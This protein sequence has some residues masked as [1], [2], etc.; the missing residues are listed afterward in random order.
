MIFA[1]S[2]AATPTLAAGGETGL[3]TRSQ[4]APRPPAR[5]EG[6]THLYL[7]DQG[8]TVSTTGAA[9][10]HPVGNRLWLRLKAVADV[11]A[12]DPGTPAD[13]AHHVHDP[14]GEAMDDMAFDAV[15][16][17]SARGGN[18]R[19]LRSE[20][21]A[22]LLFRD[23]WKGRPLELG[24]DGHASIEPDYQS[25]GGAAHGSLS[26][27]QGNITVSGYMGVSEDRIAPEDDP[28]GRDYLFPAFLGK[29][30]AGLA[31]SWI[32]TPRLALSGGASG[33]VQ[34][35]YLSSPYRG[36]VMNGMPY[37][38]RLPGQR[39][40]GTAFVQGSLYLGAGT[41]LHVRQG[42][43]A[44]DWGVRAYIPETA[45]AKE[46]GPRFMATIRHRYYIQTA[47]DFYGTAYDAYRTIRAGDVRLGR[48]DEQTAGAELEWKTPGAAQ[49]LGPLSIS[50][51]YEYAHLAYWDR[52][53]EELA[54]HVLVL[55]AALE[56]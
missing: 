12:V 7:D 5:L 15:S 54:G 44:D 27:A 32:A 3:L 36:A 18:S 31:L 39:V 13:T 24:L 10:E 55:G 6:Q 47:A 38:E 21:A 28:H 52:P 2:A 34:K 40:R 17:A 4:S 43:Y 50:I 35:G 51:G 14:S 25:F 30:S 8:L 42:A 45:L 20:G 48:L 41:A 19:E 23:A 29:Y 46:I 11:I 56:Y 1:I 33:A 9:L 53:G 22:G 16:G 26:L 49:A 37:T